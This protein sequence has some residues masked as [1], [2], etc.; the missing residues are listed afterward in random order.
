M[1]VKN[2]MKSTFETRS[3]EKQE[4]K[5][6]GQIKVNSFEME[7]VT[8]DRLTDTKPKLWKGTLPQL[9]G[10]H[11]I[12]TNRDGPLFSL[13]SFK[14]DS[15]RK[16][17]N[18]VAIHGLVF[19][20]DDLRGEQVDEVRKRLNHLA[21]A[22]ALYT[23]FRHKEAGTNVWRFRV[24]LYP[25]RSMATHEYG[26]IWD[27]LNKDLC[28]LADT[29]GRNLSRMFHLPS[30]PH[31][32]KDHVHMEFKDGLPF[33]VDELLKLEKLKEGLINRGVPS[34]PTD[35][36]KT[37]VARNSYLMRLA[38][39]MRRVG[40]D[41]RAI[42]NA[43]HEQNQIVCD[44][45]LSRNEVGDITRKVMRYGAVPELITAKHTDVGNGKR[46]VGYAGDNIRYVP[47]LKKWFHWE[48]TRWIEDRTRRI[49][50]LAKETLEATEVV[51]QKIEKSEEQS[52]LIKWIHKSEMGS[53]ISSMVAFAQSETEISIVPNQ[54]DRHKYLLNCDN[55]T[56][57]LRTGQI[58]PHNRNDFITKS[59]HVRFDETALCPSW[60]KFLHRVMRNDQEMIDFLQRAIGYSLTGDDK[61]EVFFF[62]YGKGQNGKT[63]FV[64]T[65]RCL[66]GD[67]AR[68]ANFKTFVLKKY[69]GIREDIARLK[70]ARFVSAIEG[71]RGD[72]L[73]EQMIKQLTGGDRIAERGL[74]QNTSEFDP[75][76]KIW[77]VANYK[78]N[79]RNTDEGI[80]RRVLLIPFTVQ[81]PEQ[82]RD[83][84]LLQKLLNE[85]PGILQWAI[86]GCL[87][88]QRNG[89]N[90][91]LT[92]REATQQYRKEMDTIA[93]FKDRC[94]IESNQ[95]KSQVSEIYGAYEEFCDN[96]G[97]KSKDKQEFR[98]RL[99]ELGLDEPKRS[100]GGKFYWRGIRLVTDQDTASALSPQRSEQ[101]GLSDVE[102]DVFSNVVPEIEKSSTNASLTSLTSL[103]HTNGNC[104]A[105][106]PSSVEGSNEIATQSSMEVMRKE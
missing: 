12:R 106:N 4:S 62:L 43:L 17:E 76:M 13:V 15:E 71:N 30:C 49:E 45:P 79:I 33:N 74:Y 35:K 72:R 60:E 7:G 27:A 8:F 47:E 48:G 103:S 85:L 90:P 10:S 46:L 100:T 61:E 54:F 19:D 94:C 69:D 55:G 102:L 99:K 5:A 98:E 91:P 38:G 70:G 88:W 39:T 83:R 50:C 21:Y 51:A 20:F 66:L 41:K 96:S 93:E 78:P 52:T 14:P 104:S 29:T 56:I 3:Y 73:D 36:S 75:E 81:I 80:W 28:E 6:V 101:S 65:V 22:Y 26:V 57:D 92:I 9:L 67:H 97:Y 68:S 58:R 40:F 53:H 44:P 32:R 89:L 2:E 95:A 18:V 77:L 37:S 23:T 82:E 64:E 16:D 42:L 31:E 11:E 87:D 59:I 1:K 105:S 84:D 63:K 86:R 24:I 25:K 34:I